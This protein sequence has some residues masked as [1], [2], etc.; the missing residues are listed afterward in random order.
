MM[1]WLQGK[2]LELEAGAKLPWFGRRPGGKLL[3]FSWLQR[4][5]QR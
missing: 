4:E 2:L 1:F 5:P 3:H